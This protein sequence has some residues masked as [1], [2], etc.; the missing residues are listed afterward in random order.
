[1]T[2][3]YRLGDLLTF[4]EDPNA[5]TVQA[6]SASGRWVAATRGWSQWDVDMA[7]QLGDAPLYEQGLMGGWPEI[8]DC[9]YTAIDTAQGLRGTDD[10]VFGFGYDTPEHAAESLAMLDSG[11]AA[12]SR[13]NPPIP[14]R[15]TAH[16]TPEETS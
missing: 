16:I 8:G 11:E 9:L 6:I 12:F 4:A 5:F 10:W 2:N 1:M 7:H 3:T 15:V 14:L 13:R